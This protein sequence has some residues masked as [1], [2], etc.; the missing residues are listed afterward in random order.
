MHKNRTGSSGLS[1]DEA[2]GE[3]RG[4]IE[5]NKRQHRGKFWVELMDKTTR[6]L[7]FL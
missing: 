1:K 7:P 6:L 5:E 2:L 3:K 4:Q